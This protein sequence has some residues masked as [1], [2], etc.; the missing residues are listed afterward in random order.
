MQ[1][2]TKIKEL[3]RNDPEALKKIIQL[4]K[5]QIPSS[6]TI[7]ESARLKN[8]LEVASSE[9]HKLKGTLHAIGLEHLSEKCPMLNELFKKNKKAD[10]DVMF[11]LWKREILVIIQ[12]ID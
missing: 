7:I 1:Q 12:A 11:T 6:L 2:L 10:F 8:D 4:I 9:F 5:N 3:Y